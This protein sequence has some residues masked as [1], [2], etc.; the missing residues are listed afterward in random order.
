MFLQSRYDW[1]PSSGVAELI[2]LVIVLLV[3]V[4][5]GRPLP[6]R[7]TLLRAHPRPGAPPPLASPSAWSLGV[8][9]AVVAIYVFDDSYRSAL[10]VSFIF[11]VISLSL[12]V[13]TGYLRP[14]LARP[15]DAGRRRRPS[16]SAR[17]TDDWGIPFPLAPL[18]AALGATVIGVLVGLPALRIRG[19]LVAV[20]TLMFAVAVEAVW[21]R[22]NDF[23]GGTAGS[24]IANPSFLGIDLGIGTGKAF[25]RPEFALLCLAT[26][27][28]VALGVARLRTSRLGSAMLAVRA[29]ERSAAAA[30]ISV[31]RVKLTGF[32]IGAF[33]AGLGGCLLAYKQTNVTFDSFSALLGL[34]LFASAFLAGITSVLGGIMAGLLAA[35]GLSFV[36]LE[37]SFDVGRWYGVFS[38]IGLIL[39]VIMNPEGLVGPAHA[40]T[41][42]RRQRR[43]ALLAA[44]ATRRRRR[45][46][47]PAR[48]PRIAPCPTVPRCSPSATSTSPTAASSPSTACRSRSPAGSIVGVIGPN[49]AGKTTLM[50]A[51]CGFAAYEGTV[52]LDGG[53]LDGLPPHRRARRAWPAPSR[54]ST[55]TTTSPSRRT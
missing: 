43:L 54:A 19:M 48:R 11:G 26:L 36:F 30:G 10:M 33:I 39:A 5:R 32:A 21:F 50:D 41:E 6:T 15:D 37:R 38:G 25:P 31:V 49:G 42:H 14:D 35:G 12:V 46:S 1:F 2:P 3:L 52:V 9:I 53:V 17:F 27:V 47:R 45:R 28:V 8:P 18:L 24:P 51:I 13:V 4:V 23:N 34:A 29:N 16:C 44:E 7:G 55:S 22:N 40:F 20:V